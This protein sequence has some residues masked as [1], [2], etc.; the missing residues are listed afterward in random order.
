MIDFSP[1][2]NALSESMIFRDGPLEIPGGGSTIPQKKFLQ[3]KTFPK[4]ILVSSSPSKK[5][6]LQADLTIKLNIKQISLC[7]R[8]CGCDTFYM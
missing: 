2:K 7:C 8:V 5:K 6:F 1:F 3:R 4:K